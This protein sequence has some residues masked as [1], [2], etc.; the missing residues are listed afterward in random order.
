MVIHHI[1]LESTKSECRTIKNKGQILAKTKSRNKNNN[2]EDKCACTPFRTA[3][4][5]CQQHFVPCLHCSLTDCFWD[6][7]VIKMP[8]PAKKK[9]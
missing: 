8:N 9:G 3:G 2:Y 6:N 7:N 1:L 5:Q 4:Q